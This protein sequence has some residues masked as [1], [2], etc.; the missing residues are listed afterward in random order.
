MKCS[1]T[2]M[3]Y[4]GYLRISCFN[5]CYLRNVSANRSGK[6]SQTPFSMLLSLALTV[7]LLIANNKPNMRCYA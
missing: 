2:V 5:G 4:T 3:K 1:N 6:N 7:M